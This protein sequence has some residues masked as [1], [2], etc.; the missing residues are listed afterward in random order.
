[1][2]LTEI[3]IKRPSLI[4]V[5]FSLLGVLGIYGYFQLNYNLLPKFSP[6]FVTITTVYP[7]AAPQEIETTVSKV[8]EDAVSGLD[9]V[10]QILT[11]SNEGYSQVQIEFTQDAKTEIAVQDVIRAI[12]QIKSQLPTGT[13]DPIVSKF[14]PDEIPIVRIGATSSMKE[15]DFYQFVQDFIKPEL[16]KVAGVG[17]IFVTGGVKREIRVNLDAQKVQAYGISLNTV[18]QAIAMA[19][20]DFPTGNVKEGGTQYLVR[21]AGKFQNVE[22]LNDLVVG[23]SRT[24]GEVRL[25]DIATVVDGVAEQTTFNRVDRKE[26]I[27]LSIQKQNDANGVEVSKRVRKKTEELMQTYKDKGVVLD[28]VVDS[29]TFTVDAADSVKFDLGLAIL[30]VAAV[31]LLFLHSLR[32]SLIVMIAIPASLVSTMVGVWALG[33]SLNLMTLLG[34][35]LVIGILVD[36]SIV[37]LENIY[38]HME[39]GEDRVTA[40]IKGRNEIGFAALSITLV[41]VAVFFPLSLVSGIVGNIMREFALVVVIS[42]L[43][44]L[45]VSFTITPYLASRFAKVEVMTRGSLMGW[46]GL[47]FNAWFKRIEQSYGRIIGGALRN[48]WMMALVLVLSFGSCGPITTVLFKNKLISQEF[49]KQADRGEFA[50]TVDLPPST[51]VE[52]TNRIASQI[53]EYLFTLPEVSRVLTN[54][55]SSSNVFVG[56]QTMNSVSEFNVALKP[57][58]QRTRSTD[59]VGNEIKKHI[60]NIAGAKVRV[61]PIGIFGSANDSPVQIVVSGT[62]RDLVQKAAHQVYDT[63]LA[64]QGTTDVRLSAEEGKYE[65]RIEVDRERL[66]RLGLSIGE[67]GSSMNIAL[68][69]NDD[70]K[71]REGTTE[72]PI[73]IR[74]DEKD[75]SNVETIGNL[76]IA[77]RSGQQIELKQIADISLATGT[78][79]LERRERIPSVRVLAQPFGTGAGDIADL[80]DQKMKDKL[81]PG[82]TYT[83]VGDVKNQRDGFGDMGLAILAGMIFV[84]LIMVAL[85]DSYMFPLVNLLSVF[86]APLGSFIALAMTMNSM[87]IFTMLGFI[88]LIG[89][90]MKNSILL[91]DRATANIRERGM[92]TKDALIEAGEVRLRPIVM[93]TI[94]MIFGMFPIALSHSAGAEWKSGLAWALIGGLTSSMILTLVVVPVVYYMFFALREHVGRM[95]GKD[96]DK[97]VMLPGET[98]HSTP[99]RHNSHSPSPELPADIQPAGA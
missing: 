70:V 73:R 40:S 52:E 35:S 53:E 29:S 26:S 48:G 72:Y 59:D 49:I 15:R 63:L 10:S 99:E 87:S 88:M 8:V 14:S 50:V 47:T 39:R 67:V 82:V 56:T 27:G 4:V 20:L 46:V 65:T 28:I 64:M 9:K 68:Q 24:G 23:R 69:G 93:T 43:F 58:N 84:Y 34:L 12:N 78:T 7:G 54:V 91:V 74:L 83:Y 37:V 71:F 76:T 81:P 62:N 94:A 30:I 36:D 95:F 60:M 41:D 90:V 13:K 44:S 19:N 33:F 66:A 55:G 42:T 77:N 18:Q 89:L 17:N 79:K 92:T 3:S 96:F 80:L 16:A 75:R 38:H 57:A 22:Q 31:M 86:L 61:N 85:Y 5:L 51:R 1:M 32:N 11:T 98:E 45:L 25:G 21:L 6:P 2:T 97:K